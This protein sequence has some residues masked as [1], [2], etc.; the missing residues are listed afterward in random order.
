MLFD[1]NGFKGYNDTF[2]HVAGDALLARLGGKLSDEIAP[3]RRGLPAR[4]RRVLR[5][6]RASTPSTSRRSSRSPPTRSARA[7]RGSPSPRPTAWCSLPHEADSLDHA[8][9]L[10]DERMY[11]HK[12]NR[13]SGA[14]DQARDV[15]M[16]TMHAKQPSLHDHSSHV[17]ELAVARRP[18]LRP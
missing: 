4:R 13:S 14:R 16:R 9:Q 11:A 10:A 3:L 12:H 6:A 2:G 5:R 15:L 8:L 1:L 7:A 18:P 17:A